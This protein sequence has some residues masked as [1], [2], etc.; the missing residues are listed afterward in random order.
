MTTPAPAPAARPSRSTTSRRASRS[1][2]RARSPRARP[3]ATTS[4]TPP[5]RARPT[6]SRPARPTAASG[7][8][9][10]PIVFNPATGDGNFNCRFAD[11]NPTGTPSDATSVSITITDD[12]TGAGTGSQAV[13]VNNVNPTI[14]SSAVTVSPGTGTITSTVTYTDQGVPDTERVDFQYVVT[15]GGTTTYN[16]TTGPGSLHRPRLPTPWSSDR[17]ATPSRPRSASPM[18]TPDRHLLS[19]TSAPTSTS[20]MPSSGLRSR[21]TSATSPSTAM[22][23]QSRLS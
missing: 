20:T 11:D 3:C 14:V 15:N 9:V 7:V 17:A 12:D 21:R 2:A 22:S 6:R 23:S 10:G 5:I 1:P 16:H 19:T 8:F 13:T 18:M 4:S